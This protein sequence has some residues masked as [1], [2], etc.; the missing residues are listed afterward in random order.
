MN[1]SLFKCPD[2]S[3][4]V[5]KSVKVCPNCGNNKIQKQL[6]SKEWEEM[7]PNKKKKII[8]GVGIF[9]FIYIIIMIALESNKPD[10]CDCYNVLNT[11]TERMI[12]D[13]GERYGM[14]FPTNSL[15]ND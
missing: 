2:C 6:R 12:D 1:N 13:N 3:K 11:P 15:S 14:P 10:A 5:S 7:D 9:L 8:Y 4:D